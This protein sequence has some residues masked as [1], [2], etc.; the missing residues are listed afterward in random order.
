MTP[1]HNLLNSLHLFLLALGLLVVCLNPNDALSVCALEG[2]GAR[3]W[4]KGVE[5]GCGARVWSKGVGQ[6]F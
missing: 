1:W 6:G 5:Q 3:V 2:C 4:G